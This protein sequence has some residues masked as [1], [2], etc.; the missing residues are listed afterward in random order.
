MDF[1]KNVDQ[2]YDF[3]LPVY[4]VSDRASGLSMVFD[5][6]YYDYPYNLNDFKDFA[7]IDFD[8]DDNLLGLFLKSATRQ[9]EQYLQKSLGIRTI[10]LYA[11][12][13]PKNYKLPFGPVSTITTTGFT[14]FGNL[15][16]EG[17]TDL[18]IEYITNSSLVNDHIIN[19]IY[20]QAY[21]NYENREVYKDNPMGGLINEV[22]MM[23]ATYRDVTFP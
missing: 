3:G 23:L 5:D 21:H 6:S 20:K 22:Q 8:T 13:L 2:L 7:R 17:G 16:K 12:K 18:E 19:A 4:G 10:T 14:L 9:I 15:L 11:L 1:D